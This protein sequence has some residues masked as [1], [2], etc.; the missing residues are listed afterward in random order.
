[1]GITGI[2]PY[3]CFTGKLTPVELKVVTSKRESKRAP[4]IDIVHGSKNLTSYAFSRSIVLHLKTKGFDV[5]YHE[6]FV[7]RAP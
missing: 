7:A 2:H 4:I 5:T 3:A 6:T 1:M